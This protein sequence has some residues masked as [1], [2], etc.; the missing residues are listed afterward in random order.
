MGV[1]TQPDLS[2]QVMTRTQTKGA[3]SIS[4]IQGTRTKKDVGIS[5]DRTITRGSKNKGGVETQST[6]I[7]TRGRAKKTFG[8]QCGQFGVEQ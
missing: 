3:S 1:D 8:D 4:K 5:K 7:M 2:P 6:S